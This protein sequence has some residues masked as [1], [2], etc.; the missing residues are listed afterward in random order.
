MNVDKNKE[1][2]ENVDKDND[3]VENNHKDDDLPQPSD[4]GEINTDDVKKRRKG[5][6]NTT[7][8]VA[9]PVSLFSEVKQHSKLSDITEV[10]SSKANTIVDAENDSSDE[11]EAKYSEDEFDFSSNEIDEDLELKRR[12]SANASW[13][14]VLSGAVTA[15]NTAA[16]ANEDTNDES[17]AADGVFFET[18]PAILEKSDDSEDSDKRWSKAKKVVKFVRPVYRPMNLEHVKCKVPKGKSD[19]KDCLSKDPV[20]AGWAKMVGRR[21]KSKVVKKSG[22]SPRTVTVRQGRSLPVGLTMSSSPYAAKAQDK[23]VLRHLDA[24]RMSIDINLQ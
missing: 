2:N 12:L 3:K 11:A 17:D 14:K 1:N 20:Y 23:K 5:V 19:Q 6:D 16:E 24:K 13:D 10:D 8:T 22:E 7:I 4:V 21:L 15:S 9:S 18:M